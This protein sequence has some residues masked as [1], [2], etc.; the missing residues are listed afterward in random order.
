MCNKPIKLAKP[1]NLK[2]KQ[3]K[4]NGRVELGGGKTQDLQP[5]G[6]KGKR[7]PGMNGKINLK[8]Y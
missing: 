7:V 1:V 6:V 8:R 4:M 5:G 2:G 3:I